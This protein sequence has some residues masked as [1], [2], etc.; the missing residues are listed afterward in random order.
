[1]QWLT[2]PSSTEELMDTVVDGV[3]FQR[4]LD[5]VS[6]GSRYVQTRDSAFRTREGVFVGMPY[7]EARKLTSDSLGCL[8]RWA[9]VLKVPD[10]W[11]AAFGMIDYDRRTME[12]DS[13]IDWFYRKDM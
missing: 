5:D 2:S 4:S 12:T 6:I 9:F 8:P 10:G 11:N 1:M 7:R 3:R 13:T